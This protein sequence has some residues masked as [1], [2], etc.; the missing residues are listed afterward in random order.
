MGSRFSGRMAEEIKINAQISFQKSHRVHR[1]IIRILH[2]MKARRGKKRQKKEKLRA[3]I[4]FG[5][6]VNLQTLYRFL[7]FFLSYCPFFESRFFYSVGIISIF[8]MRICCPPFV[9]E[10]F[11]DRKR[12][13]SSAAAYFPRYLHRNTKQRP[14]RFF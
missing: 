6:T 11:C 10:I 2:N 13:K 4:F 8:C 3:V 14:K 12:E 7:S 5:L 1:I 9:S